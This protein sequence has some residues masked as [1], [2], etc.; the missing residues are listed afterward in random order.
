MRRPIIALAVVGTAFAARAEPAAERFIQET[1]GVYFANDPR[2]GENTMEI[3]PY[4]PRKAYIRLRTWWSNGHM[5]AAYGMFR[6]E[7]SRY[8]YEGKFL[9]ST[10]CRMTIARQR[11]RFV[12][13]VE[14]RERHESMQACLGSCGARGSFDRES[15][16]RASQRRPIRYLRRLIDSAEYEAAVAHD[17]GRITDSD[18]L[19]TNPLPE[20]EAANAYEAE[21]PRDPIP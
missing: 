13:A 19:W 9:G 21:R 3:V 5:C 2:V 1:A 11:G 14:D 4:G 20:V 7:P 6:A 8:V 17:A 15:R 16:F 18:T 12:I 10:P